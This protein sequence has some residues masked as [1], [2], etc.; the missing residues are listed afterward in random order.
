M[1]WTWADFTA[2]TEDLLWS[3][4]FTVAVRN[5]WPSWR[6]SGSEERQAAAVQTRVASRNHPINPKKTAVHIIFHHKRSKAFVSE[7]NRGTG[8]AFAAHPHP[9]VRHSVFFASP[10]CLTCAT[11]KRMHFYHQHFVSH[12]FFIFF[13]WL[14]GHLWS[15]ASALWLCDSDN[16]TQPALRQGM[17]FLF[18]PLW[19][20]TAVSSIPLSGIMRCHR[21]QIVPPNLLAGEKGLPPWITLWIQWINKWSPLPR[22]Q[23]GMEYSPSRFQ[24]DDI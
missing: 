3:L 2:I 10:C 24:G 5:Q 9:Q 1:S 20:D 8:N 19:G 7:R 4:R 14:D 12:F 17:A 16:P 18:A 22:R 21:G 15:P 11:Q 13:I 23:R 6:C